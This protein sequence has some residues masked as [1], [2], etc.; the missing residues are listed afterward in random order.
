V[1]IKARRYQ[2]AKSQAGSNLELAWWVFMRV[3][4]VVLV[5]L[6][7]GHIYMDNIMMDAGKTTYTY[8]AQRLSDI[9]WKLYDWLMLSLGLLHGMNGVRYVLDDWVRSPTRRLWW[10]VVIYGLA[11]VAF[12]VGS[13][14]LFNHH[15]VIPA[16]G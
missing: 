9:T 2:E 13:F 12:V 6:V 1:A 4:G 16:Q 8:I 15:F 10:K 14:S 7:L 3:S 5:F 11:I